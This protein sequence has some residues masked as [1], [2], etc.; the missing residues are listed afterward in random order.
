M[1]EDTLQRTTRPLTVVALLLAGGWILA[2]ALFKLL[3]GS[4]ALL[5][6]FMRDLPLSRQKL[7]QGLDELRGGGGR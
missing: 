5:P 7:I 1:P 2:G 6:A 3:Q 4:P